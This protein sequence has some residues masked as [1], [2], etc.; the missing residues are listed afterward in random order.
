[1]FN[2]AWSEI[3]LIVAVA[4]IAI[5]P[6]DLPAAIRTVSGAI[7]RMRRMASEFQGHMDDL[8]REASLADVG[9]DLAGLRDAIKGDIERSVDPDGSLGAAF[10]DPLAAATEVET[11]APAPLTESEPPIPLPD[12][13]PPGTR[14][15]LE[16]LARRGLGPPAFVPPNIVRH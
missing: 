16:L 13:V 2:F 15:P 9:R 14:L 1:M 10:A 11:I 12:F 4:L 5:G 6:K 7:R 3:A 8:V